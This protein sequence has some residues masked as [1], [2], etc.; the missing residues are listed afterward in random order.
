M[1]GLTPPALQ[2][3]SS[4]EKKYDR[5]LRLW[6]ANGQ[7]AL[8]DANVLLVNSGSGVVG[9]ETLKNLILPGVGRFAI[10]DDATVS[11]AD[12][13]VNFF[14]DESSLGQS[15]ARASCELL[16]ELN[17]DVNGSYV[18]GNIADQDESFLE[19]YTVLI[20]AAPVAG[21]TLQ[22]LA[23]Y[24]REKN[25]PLAYVHS[26]GFFSRFS[27][28]LPSCFPIVETHPDASS[29]TD[30]RLL[31]PWPELRQLVRD[32]T[33]DLESLSEHAH[34]HVPYLL[35]L[36]HYLENWEQSHNGRPPQNY[37]EKTE[38]REM[39]RRGARTDNPEGGE[40]NYDEAVGAV[41]KSL[42]PYV[43][44]SAVRDVLEA[45][46]C[47]APTKASANFW[48][49][50]AAIATFHGEHSTLPLTGAVP[51]MKA[52]SADYIQ[53]Q[54]VYKAKARKD[55][56]EVLATVRE[57]EAQLGRDR[58]VDEKE[59]EAFYQELH[60]PESLLPLYIAFLAHESL[61]SAA[62]S[63][64][65]AVV[66]TE[67]TLEHASTIV[68]DLWRE[69]RK[70]FQAEAKQDESLQTVKT[71]IKKYIEEIVRAGGGE[72]HNTS[73][74]TGGMVA[75]EI[76]KAITKQY[77]P[78]DNTCLFDGIGSRTSAFKV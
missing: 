12:L 72:L 3:P 33:K 66:D 6:G 68:E 67:T 17:P 8:E 47:T 10:L 14:L 74:L 75:Q 18:H 77:I 13:G 25:K 32:K 70:D 56:A 57:L 9:V 73:A 78:V 24:A 61:S 62:E 53:L 37:G 7:A 23:T 42:N 51:D 44:T 54:N 5:Q 35:L 69:A 45:E 46:E 16:Q 31:N 48:L 21:K 28:V 64:S 4:K 36:L 30:L 34:G 15:R 19:A 11:E 50:A 49:I 39:V 38:F 76:I 58:A 59:V 43:L 71:T 55:Y 26:V 2:G 63:G 1:G 29:T 40:E 22:R 60:D 52:Q 20:V 65:G 27:L 41:L